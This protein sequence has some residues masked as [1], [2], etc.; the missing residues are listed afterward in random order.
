MYRV[1]VLGNVFGCFSAETFWTISD[2]ACSPTYENP[3]FRNESTSTTFLNTSTIPNI[4]YLYSAPTEINYNFFAKWT[5]HVLNF[6]PAQATRP[7]MP[8]KTEL[9]EEGANTSHKI[10]ARAATRL[11]GRKDSRSPAECSGSWLWFSILRRVFMRLFWLKLH[12]FVVSWLS[13]Q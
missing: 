2:L 3:G 11:K 4:N 9:R 6:T 1:T 13:S 12:D 5:R 10:R 8:P 7:V